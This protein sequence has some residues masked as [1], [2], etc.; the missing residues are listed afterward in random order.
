ME[1]RVLGPLEV[2]DNGRR[3]NLGG[4]KQQAVLASLLVHAD[5]TVALE[6]LVD[7]LWDEAPP[8]T[9]Q[10]TIRVYVSRLRKLLRDGAIERRPG[11]YVLQL[12][13]DGFDLR[14][15]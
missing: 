12:S 15:F 1:Y 14:Q 4:A 2:V 7:E 8:E 10:K 9:A 13:D 11:G 6:R 3:L 5:Q